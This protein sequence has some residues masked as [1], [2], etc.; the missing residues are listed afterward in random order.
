MITKDFTFDLDDILKRRTTPFQYKLRIVMNCYTVKE[1]NIND[2]NSFSFK[3]THKIN[4]I[5]FDDPK[6]YTGFFTWEKID[7]YT[8]KVS[9]FVK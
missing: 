7:D 4:G 2:D 1:L 6:E 3:K 8:A 5:Q 9:I